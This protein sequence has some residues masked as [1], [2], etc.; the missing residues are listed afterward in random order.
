LRH[1]RKQPNLYLTFDKAMRL[2]KATNE[3]DEIKTLVE[4]RGK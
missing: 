4:Y 2:V 3:V 1:R